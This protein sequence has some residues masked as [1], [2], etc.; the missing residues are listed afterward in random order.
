MGEG[1]PMTGHPQG[2]R[3]ENGDLPGERSEEG[4]VSAPDSS[5]RDDEH[6][7]RAATDGEMTSRDRDKA[8]PGPGMDQTGMPDPGESVAEQEGNTPDRAPL[9]H[10]DPVRTTPREG[11]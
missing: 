2:G 1:N 9:G 4:T 3:D 8:G 5:G 6:A 7:S 11:R 10:D